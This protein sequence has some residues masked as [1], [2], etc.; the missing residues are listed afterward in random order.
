MRPQIRRKRRPA[1]LLGGAATIAAVV[2]ALAGPATARH[3]HGDHSSDD[4]AGTI[5][6]FDSESGVLRIDLVE[7][8]QISGLV[9]KYTWIDDGQ[10]HQR[11]GSD[12]AKLARRHWC[13]GAEFRRHH[14]HHGFGHRHHGADTSVLVP[15]ATVEDA[16]LCL[17]DGKAWFAKVELEG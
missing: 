10:W 12:R 1:L 2:L 16:F 8:G 4:P 15:G 3:H 6:S 11:C 14:H 5:A 7:G 17:K 13:H 9:T